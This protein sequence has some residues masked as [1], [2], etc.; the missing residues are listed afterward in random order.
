MSAR[1]PRSEDGMEILW[2]EQTLAD[3]PP[4]DEWLGAEE[5]ARLATMRVPKRRADWRL[6]RWTAKLAVAQYLGLSPNESEKIQVSAAASG[7]PEVSID[8]EDRRLTISISHRD[9]MAACAVAERVA[10]IG[11]DLELIEPRSEAFIRD[12]FTVAEQ[13]TI[14]RAPSAERDRL[15]ALLW[16]AKE[17]ALKAIREGLRLDTRS[18][19]AEPSFDDCSAGWH[20]LVCRAPHTTF[21][22]WWQDDGSMV[23]TLIA[24]PQSVASPIL[25]KAVLRA[26]ADNPTHVSAHPV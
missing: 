7:A 10:A 25:H 5:R 26:L 23:R 14:A 2:F 4:G 3:V 15:V 13:E 24:S 21:R 20:R 12:Y 8:G 16:S 6:G 9:G 11:C 19:V 1:W 17:S 18:I 22:G